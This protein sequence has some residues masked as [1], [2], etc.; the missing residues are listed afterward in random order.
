MNTPIKTL[1]AGLGLAALLPLS[2]AQNIEFNGGVVDL[3][4]YYASQEGT[5]GTWYPIFRNK[6]TTSATGNTTTFNG[7]PG[8]VGNETA[9]DVSFSNLTVNVSTT[10]AVTVGSTSYFVATASGSPFLNDGSTPD[11]GFRTRLREDQNALGIGE[12]SAANQFDSLNFTLNLGASTF[13]G[14]PLAGNADVSLLHWDGA[15]NP[16]PMIDTAAGSLTANFGNYA[17]VH[18]NWGFSDYGQ[19]TLSF[20][21]QG[22]G[23]T[24]GNTASTGSLD[25]TFNVIPEPSTVMLLLTGAIGLIGARKLKNRNA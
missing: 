4:F 6:G 22:V 10:T 13:N 7:F 9:N 24:Y 18:R 15:D 17:H 19:Y 3:V 16:A 14:N 11:L 23:G 12:I 21:L 25:I 20:D 1:L 8:I 5:G 2:N